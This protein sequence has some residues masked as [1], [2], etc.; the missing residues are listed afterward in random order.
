MSELSFVLVCSF[1]NENK[2]K[3]EMEMKKQGEEV[4]QDGVLEPKSKQEEDDEEEQEEEESERQ[5][6]ESPES[7]QSLFSVIAPSPD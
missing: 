5:T 6:P 7:G 3:K 4:V 2:L 1:Q